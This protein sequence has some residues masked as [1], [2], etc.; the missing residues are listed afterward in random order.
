MSTQKIQPKEKPRTNIGLLPGQLRL[1]Q[2]KNKSFLAAIGGVGSGKTSFG[3]RWFH[4][5]CKLNYKSPNSLIVAENGKYVKLRFKEYI[6]YLESLKWQEGKHFKVNRSVPYSIKYYFGHE[7]LFWSAE[8]KIVSLNTSHDWQDEAALFSRETVWEIDQRRRCPKST[9][10]QSLTTTSP[11]GMNH[12]YEFYGSEDMQREGRFSFSDNKLVLHSSSYD[13]YFLPDDYLKNLE[14]RFGWDELYF[15]NYVMGEWVNLARNSFYFSATDDNIIET[16]P[17]PQVPRLVLSFDNNVGKMQWIVIQTIGSDYHV[18]A[19][20]NGTARNIDDA[21]SEFAKTFPTFTWADHRIEVAGDAT[22]HHRSVQTYTTGYE[23]VQAT[24]KKLGYRNVHVVAYF[25][26]PLVAE[27]SMTTNRALKN[28]KLLISNKC[29]RVIHSL[30]ATQS[31]G[32]GGIVKPSNDE[33]THA[34]EAVDHALCVIDPIKI[35]SGSSGV[36]W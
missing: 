24:L 20:N 12:T 5:R 29:K 8:T 13:N 19:A 26:N 34:M 15:R 4:S 21:C 18:V 32:K 1:L 36:S 3:C 14:D 7:V 30:R 6:A 10:R 16:T 28:L 27:R 9:L 35:K 33:V 23:V 2:E 17:R 31:D 11:E 25:G 22:L